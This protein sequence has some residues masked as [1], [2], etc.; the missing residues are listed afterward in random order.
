MRLTRFQIVGLL[1]ALVSLQT[2]AVCFVTT[3][4]SSSNTGATWESSFDLPTALT[5]ASCA[6]VWVAAGVYVPTADGNPAKSFAVRPGTSVV[7][8]FAGTEVERT[9]RNV[10]ANL[11]VLSG[12]VDHNDA[13]LNGIDSDASQ[14]L[15]NNSY[16]VLLLDT[17]VLGSVGADTLI[18]G[19]II[20]GGTGDIHYGG[21][22]LL[23][24]GSSGTTCSPT[25]SQLFFSGN[26]APFAGGAI[27]NWSGGG[28]SSPH[29]VDCTFSGNAAGSGAAIYNG[30]LGGVSSPIVSNS[31]FS[32]N[33]ADFGS[34]IANAAFGGTTDP[35]L[36]NLTIVHNFVR[37]PGLYIGSAIDN[38][39][40][41]T[42]EGKPVLRNVILWDNPAEISGDTA[43][44]TLDHA[45][46]EGATCPSASS[47]CSDL[48]AD[49]PRVDALRYN[50]GPTPTMEAWCRKLGYRF[51]Q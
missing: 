6:E 46:I 14:A 20:T 40:G 21:G 18:D 35:M 39:V 48:I 50:G 4:G 33:T 1:M 8:G 47:S 29:I 43:N 32:N 49:D 11:T 27:Y 30:G 3:A 41:E 10:A 7:G 24:F 38:E 42:G 37:D 9:Q 45:V 17:T 12:D 15:G 16:H 19:F 31:T 13:G 23:C 5:N 22:G 44:F 2:R 28:T 36:I 34:A 25:L 26:S 51:G